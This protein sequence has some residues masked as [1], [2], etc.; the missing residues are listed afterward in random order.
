MIKLT[1]NSRVSTI[2]FKVTAGTGKNARNETSAALAPIFPRKRNVKRITCLVPFCWLSKL[3]NL[4]IKKFTAVDRNL[5]ETVAAIIEFVMEWPEFSR[6]F[7]TK[8]KNRKSTPAETSDET[9][10]F[11]KSGSFFMISLWQKILI[12]HRFLNFFIFAP[13]FKRFV[14]Q[15]LFIEHFMEL[16]WHKAFLIVIIGFSMEF[17]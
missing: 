3:Q 15:R 13:F 14:R 16:Y 9:V 12:L 10:N 17:F 5:A 8:K 4:L 11:A 2:I 1:K 6:V 7:W